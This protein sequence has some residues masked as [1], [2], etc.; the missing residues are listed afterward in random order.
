MPITGRLRTR[1][2]FTLVELLI[3]LAMLGIV[4]SMITQL[5]MKQQRFFQRLSDQITV[6]RELRT[7][8]GTL[9]SEVRAVSSAGGDIAAFSATGITFRATLGASFVC[10]KASP[11]ELLL[12]P[13]NSA[14]T[15]T[16][17]WVTPPTAGD[18]VFA[19]R[20]DSAGVS[21]D[22]WS[23]HRITA[24]TQS[25]GLCVTSPYLDP[26]LD[27]GKL[28][29][30]L[31]VTPAVPDSVV[32]GAALRFTRAAR[33]ALAPA[34]SG[35][36]YLQRQEV[37]GG[38]WTTPVSISGPYMAPGSNGLGGLVLSYR[39]SLDVAIAAG[40]MSSRIARIDIVLRAQGMA[41]ATPGNPS[42]V[43]SVL[44]SVA[45]RNRR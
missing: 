35:R 17:N 11:T 7:A 44:L 27:A 39:D 41:P 34:T 23:A 3:T 12:P 15:I 37:Q 45:V 36:W 9:P 16:T 28:R 13:V 30:R 38:Q 42:V 18:T 5:M 1:S 29:Y 8:L 31:A 32:R 40:E 4:G 21:G 20:H 24:I 33:Y 19:L 25:A 10:E 22:Y 43:D 2:G 26:V 6:R 14:R